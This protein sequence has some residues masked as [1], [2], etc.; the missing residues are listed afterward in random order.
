MYALVFYMIGLQRAI[1][2]NCSFVL[3]GFG[4]SNHTRIPKERETR[5]LPLVCFAHVHYTSLHPQSCHTRRIFWCGLAPISQT[6]KKRQTLGTFDT[7]RLMVCAWSGAQAPLKQ[8]FGQHDES[9]PSDFSSAWIPKSVK[10]ASQRVSL[11]TYPC[12]QTDSF[13]IANHADELGKSLRHTDPVA[14]A[15]IWVGPGIHSK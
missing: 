12:Y 3:E 8:F 10:S 7:S 13:C 11:S 9:T 2:P 14:P 4:W 6:C 1:L 15:Y 5:G